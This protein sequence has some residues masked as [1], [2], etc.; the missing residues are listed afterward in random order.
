MKMHEGTLVHAKTA[1]FPSCWQEHAIAPC[2]RPLAT[3]YGKS[4]KRTRVQKSEGRY[5]GKIIAGMETGWGAAH[6]VLFN[7]RKLRLD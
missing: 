2:H 3:T 5:P 1:A 6:K 4:L 7:E